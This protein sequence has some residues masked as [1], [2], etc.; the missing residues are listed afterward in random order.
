LPRAREDQAVILEVLSIK[1]K[2]GVVG[3]AG[4]NI[5]Q[6][7]LDKCRE[8]GREVARRDMIIVTGACPGLPQAAVFGA[9]DEGGMSIGIS[10][11]L[12]L[13]D[14]VNRFRSPYEEYDALIFTGSGLMGREVDV[15][16]TADV[17]I[18][19]GG[20]SGTL[21]EFA[22]AYD[23][24]NIIGVLLGTGGVAENLHHI[25][26]FIQEKDTGAEI[27]YSD[28]PL[29]LMEKVMAAHDQRIV[30]GRAYRI[31]ESWQDWT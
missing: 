14:H 10:P 21:G 20:R 18:V 29:E 22:I 12:C 7:A 15:I 24:G 31:N 27:I 17:V 19:A 11:A 4:G 25:S 6:E 13:D 30:E 2:V 26:S 8:L 16:R 9:K 28:D 23:D 5:T 3:S 1:R